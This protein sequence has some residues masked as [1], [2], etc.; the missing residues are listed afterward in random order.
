MPAH[1]KLSVDQ[2]ADLARRFRAGEQAEA[3][4]ERFGVSVRSVY[5][6]ARGWQPATA[7]ATD[8]A[9]SLSFRAPAA[10]VAAFETGGPRGGP[11][12]AAARHS[13]R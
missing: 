10:E 13:A 1:A 4:A 11:G 3:L 9:M 7:A 6:T 12:D 2:Q 8:P 5:R